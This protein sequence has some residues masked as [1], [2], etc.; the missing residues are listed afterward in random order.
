M[1]HRILSHDTTVN[2]VINSQSTDPEPLPEDP[3]ID[4]SD[5]SSEDSEA[6]KR[7]LRAGKPGWVYVVRII[8]GP[9]KIGVTWGADPDERIHKIHCSLPYQIETLGVCW[10]EHASSLERSLHR[11]FEKSRIKNEWFDLTEQDLHQIFSAYPF[12]RN[13]VACNP[14]FN[15]P[16][17][18]TAWRKMMRKN[19]FGL[20]Q[21]V[22]FS[23][24][25][26][27]E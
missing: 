26:E 19:R 6:P 3:K 2:V 1:T 14:F 15:D 27:S 22:D 10:H 23:L 17:M 24:S 4:C 16:E 5:G 8:D 25:G 13:G 9:Y 20:G 12:K 18:E 7:R 11:H 21:R